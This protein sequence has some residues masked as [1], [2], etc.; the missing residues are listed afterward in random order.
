MRNLL[1][2]IFTLLICFFSESSLMAQGF[3]QD[4]TLIGIGIGVGSRY[5]GNTIPPIGAHFEKGVA[6]KIS[7][8]AFAGFT[9]TELSDFKST[10]ILVGGRGAYH[11]G[12]HLD[13]PDE[14]DLYGGLGIYYVN[15]SI[16]SEVRSGFGTE[17]GSSSSGSVDLGFFTGARYYFSDQAGVFAELGTSLAWIQLGLALK[18]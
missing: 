8:G 10:I 11:Y 17:T 9:S 12:N 2:F 1:Y 5:T 13:I 4:N 6:E 15:T 3:D 18:L 16:K 14:W 7:V